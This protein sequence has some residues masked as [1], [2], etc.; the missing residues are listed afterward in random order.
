LRGN[1]LC[2]FRGEIHDDYTGAG[3][4]Q[5]QRNARAHAAT[6]TGNNRDFFGEILQ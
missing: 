2:S 1:G 5:P 3:L 4:G 6:G